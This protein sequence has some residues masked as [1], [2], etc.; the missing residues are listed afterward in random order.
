MSTYNLIKIY[1]AGKCILWVHRSTIRTATIS[2]TIDGSE[3]LSI[4]ERTSYYNSGLT[5]VRHVIL[6]TE[7]SARALADGDIFLGQCA[8]HTEKS[9]L[10]LLMSMRRLHP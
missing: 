7:K 4:A 6:E 8:E 9:V 10:P 2:C 1:R 5:H 3:K